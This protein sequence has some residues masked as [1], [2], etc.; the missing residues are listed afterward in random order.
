MKDRKELLNYLV[1]GFITTF[2]NMISY[3]LLAKLLTTDFKTATTIAWFLSVLFAFVTN[4]LFVFNSRHK[5]LFLMTKELGSFL[6]SRIL[7]YGLDIFSMI[8]LVE[9][10]LLNDIVSKGIANALVILFNYFAS[11]FFVF[12]QLAGSDN[13]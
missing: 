10:L 13:K 3:A 12:R 4:K 1:F 5:N 9:V 11:K 7:S 6:L 2:I 8:F